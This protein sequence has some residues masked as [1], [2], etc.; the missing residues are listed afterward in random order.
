MS[1][2]VS[3]AE[4]DVKAEAPSENNSEAEVEEPANDEKNT[5]T[6]EEKSSDQA[7]NES[8]ADTKKSVEPVTSSESS[9]TFSQNLKNH[10][11]STL[12]LSFLVFQLVK[13]SLIKS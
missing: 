8:I 6:V 3:D 13:Q 2:Q 4:P 11:H 1:S 5:E 10:Q 12:D 7:D 9:E